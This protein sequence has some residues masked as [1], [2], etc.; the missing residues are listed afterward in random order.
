MASFEVEAFI[1]DCKGAIGAA[2]AQKAVHEIVSRVVSSP[3]AVVERLG[4]PTAGGIQTIY[5]SLNLTILNIVWAPKMTLL[6]HDHRMWAVIGIY[7][8][9]E[10]NIFW[11]R[12]ANSPTGR[13]E[14]VSANAI[15]ERD[16]VMLGPDIVH[17]VT[18]PIPRLTGAIHVYGGDFFNADRS[19][20]DPESLEERSCDVERLLAQYEE[21][22]RRW[23]GLH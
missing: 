15:S 7:G 3:R 6:P 12:I 11:K 22:N 10:D 19:E 8:G 23:F 21:D 16:A 5:H 1:D 13:V 9:R 18:N 20:W 14:A 2:G 17:S 4:E